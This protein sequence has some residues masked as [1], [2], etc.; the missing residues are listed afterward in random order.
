MT[1]LHIFIL[2]KDYVLILA[3]KSGMN[4]FLM[5]DLY[6]LVVFVEVTFLQVVKVIFCVHYDF[7]LLLLNFH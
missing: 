6:V 4:D 1:I 5:R 3:D 2:N 7:N